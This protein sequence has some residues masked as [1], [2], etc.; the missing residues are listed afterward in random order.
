MSKQKDLVEVIKCFC[1]KIKDIEIG[2]S[3]LQYLLIDIGK[4]RNVDVTR[5]DYY[6]ELDRL[7]DVIDSNTAIEIARRMG[8][9]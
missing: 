1:K 9:K 5:S 3:S 6:K 7:K 2:S 4:E 8:Y